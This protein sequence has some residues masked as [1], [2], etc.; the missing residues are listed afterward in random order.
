M[1]TDDARNDL[2]TWLRD[3]HAL[4]KELVPILESQAN[5]ARGHAEIHNRLRQHAQ[6]TR[7][8][9]ELVERC[10]ARLGAEAS[11]VKDTLMTLSGTLAGPLFGLP[12]DDLVRIAVLDYA[13][14]NLEIA[15]YRALVHASRLLG[16]DDV[17]RTC[18]EILR[19]EERMAAWL[20]QQIPRIVESHLGAGA[21]R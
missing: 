15:T 8:H 17:A 7:R 4:E 9:Q 13:S 18:E 5:L 20:Q 21:A 1:T 11:L 12:H 6:E 3:A 16:Y 10:L 2:V 14:E 19:E